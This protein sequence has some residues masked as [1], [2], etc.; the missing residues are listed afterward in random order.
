MQCTVQ[1]PVHNSFPVVWLVNPF[2]LWETNWNNMIS[3]VNHLQVCLPWH[4][5]QKRGDFH[6]MY[7]RSTP[8]NMG[9]RTL[10][11]F[12]LQTG[13]MCQ[14]GLLQLHQIWPAYRTRWWAVLFHPSLHV[15]SIPPVR[16]MHF[17]PSMVHLLPCLMQLTPEEIAQLEL[18]IHETAMFSAQPKGILGVW[19]T[20][21][22]RCQQQPIPGETNAKVVLAAVDQK[23]LQHHAFDKRPV[24][25][26]SSYGGKFFPINCV[27]LAWDICIR[28]KWQSCVGCFQ[29]MFPHM[30]P[31]HWSWTLQE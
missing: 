3:A 27:F 20:Y 15:Q 2:Q 6:G 17:E 12:C 18:S 22:N 19:L 7:Q 31:F 8:I 26:P 13:Y 21:S 14:Q 16:K 4:T 9:S 28:K 11:K 25:P 29:V 24:W 5:F 1:H 30:Q 23:V 10:N